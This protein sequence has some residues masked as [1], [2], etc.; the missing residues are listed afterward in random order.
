MFYVFAALFYSL[1]GSEA[2]FIRGLFFRLF[3]VLDFIFADDGHSQVQ[4]GW[5]FY[6]LKLGFTVFNQLNET[7]VQ[8]VPQ[9]YFVIFTVSRLLKNTIYL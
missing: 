6:H 8:S 7:A 1:Y 2:T 9:I 4:N 5:K 3:T